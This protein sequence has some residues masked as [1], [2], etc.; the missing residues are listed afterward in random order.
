MGRVYLVGAGPGHPDLITVRGRMVLESVDAIVYDNLIPSEL[1]IT[2]PAHIERRYV[3]KQSSVHALPQEEIN[4]LLV[5]LA[6]EGKNVA[7]L[8]GG[9][10]FTFGRGAEEATHLRQNGIEFEVVPGVTSGSAALAFAGIPPTDR[11]KAS[12]VMFVTGHKASDPESQVCWEWLAK[13]RCATIVI[14]MGVAEMQHLVDTLIEFGMDPN[15]PSAVVERGTFPTQRVFES[16]MKD[17]PATAIAN[18]VRPPSLI[19]IGEVVTLREQVKWFAGRPLF[20]KRIL[21]TRPA[22]QAHEI[23]REL[24]DLGA[25]V[26]PYPT[27]ATKEEIDNDGWQRVAD[28]TNSNRWLILTSENGV[29][30]FLRQ[31]ADRFGDVRRLADYK[32]A[33]IGFGTARALEQAHLVADFVAKEATGKSLATEMVE[34]LDLK[35]ATIVRVRGTLA[36]DTVESILSAATDRIIPLT[37]YHTYIPD[38]SDD[39]KAKL[40]RYPP[41]YIMFTSGSSSDGYVQNLSDDERRTLSAAR[42]VS[43]G[44]STTRVVKEHGLTVALEAGTHSIPG[45]IEKLIEDVASQT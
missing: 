2:L 39:L 37:V 8:K 11:R 29:R 31:F 33:A 19:V 4:A 26:L 14:Y 20:G 24:R 3:G 30:Y 7:R 12:M 44:P 27:I 18:N 38:W 28:E 41:D 22:D 45:V 42:I 35:E 40:L 43:I 1:L 34:Q 13:A 9:D 16:P 21:V 25:E 36:D 10:P 6:R 15:T 32:I 5:T 23:Y 17:L